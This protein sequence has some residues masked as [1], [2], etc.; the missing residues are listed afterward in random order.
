MVLG[1]GHQG[2]ELL[3]GAIGFHLHLDVDLLVAGWDT[4]I[5]A[6]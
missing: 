1:I 6:E 2:V 3:V 4:V 5:E